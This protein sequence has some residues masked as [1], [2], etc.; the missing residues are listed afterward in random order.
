MHPYDYE[1]PT[2]FLE[3]YRLDENAKAHLIDKQKVYRGEVQNGFLFT[4][5]DD[6][7]YRICIEPLPKN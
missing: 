7:S 3:V 4:Q 2:K 6:D 5:K 1:A